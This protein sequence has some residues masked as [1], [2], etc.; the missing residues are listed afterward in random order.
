MKKCFI[1]A[2]MMV[3][4]ALVGCSGTKKTAPKESFKYSAPTNYDENLSFERTL[5]DYEIVTLYEDIARQCKEIQSITHKA[6]SYSCG[7][8]QN[9]AYTETQLDFYEDTASKIKVK[10]VSK[11]IRNGIEIE[12]ETTSDIYSFILAGKHVYVTSSSDPNDSSI[13]CLNF[14]GDDASYYLEATL[15]VTILGSGQT[16]NYYYDRGNRYIVYAKYTEEST[17][18]LVGNETKTE[19]T[20]SR[21][22][23]IMKIDKNGKILK[24]TIYTESLSNY[25]KQTGD[26]YN[27]LYTTSKQSEEGVFKYGS[28]R[29]RPEVNDMLGKKTYLLVDGATLSMKSA[30]LTTSE[31]ILK[32][33]F[34]T[35]YPDYSFDKKDINNGKIKVV[36]SLDDDNA[37]LTSFTIDYVIYDFTTND[38]Q[39]KSQTATVNFAE[40]LGS[41]LP[42]YETTTGEK[43]F[44]TEAEI[45]LTFD[46]DY[47]LN[48]TTGEL[49]VNSVSYNGVDILPFVD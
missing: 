7:A 20:V 12:E 45:A 24:S 30:Y 15:N 17:P 29:N 13:Q 21:R 23:Y 40:V 44:Y 26:Y 28:R 47:S 43:F 41:S 42:L 22:Q 38:I 48:D 35:S 37:L 49:T 36:V 9:Y 1:F 19:N 32:D 46:I 11:S 14:N 4:I 31:N 8:S 6:Y 34:S 16:F 33:S 27:D 5:T 10:N 18:K 25:N 39:R 3:F 2:I